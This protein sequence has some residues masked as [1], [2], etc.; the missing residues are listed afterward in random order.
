MPIVLQEMW[1]ASGASVARIPPS[2]NV[3]L[4]TAASSASMVM[5]AAPRQASAMCS[6]AVAP[7]ATSGAA[8]SGLRL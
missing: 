6:A 4:S 7:R 3:A 1:I 5:T 8:F 2:P